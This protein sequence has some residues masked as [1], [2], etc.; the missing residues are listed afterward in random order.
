M[1]GWAYW[2]LLLSAVSSSTLVPSAA[3]ASRDADFAYRYSQVWSA[4]VRMIR[5]DL[6]LPV[7]EQDQAI[8]YVLFEWKDSAGRSHPGSFELVRTEDDRGE[9]VRAVVQIPAMPSYVEQ[10]LLDRLAR[11]LRA[12]FGAPPERRRPP[13]PPRGDEPSEEPGDEDEGDSDPDATAHT[14]G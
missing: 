10:M 2:A 4:A 6:R 11:K 8:G 7:G 9:L 5:V 14:A 12:E 1:R 13:E 3:S